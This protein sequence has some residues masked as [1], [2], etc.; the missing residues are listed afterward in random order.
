MIAGRMIFPGS[1]RAT[2]QWLLERGALD[3]LMGVD[4]SGVSLDSAYKAADHLLSA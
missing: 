3:E 4:L 2:H 1:E